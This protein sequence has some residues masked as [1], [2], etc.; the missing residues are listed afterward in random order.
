QVPINAEFGIQDWDCPESF[1]MHRMVKDIHSA[2]NQLE[3]P[4]HHTNEQIDHVRSTI[5]SQWANPPKDV[6]QLIPADVL[7]SIKKQALHSLGIADARQAPF[8]IVLVDGILLFHDGDQNPECHPGLACDTGVFIYAQYDTL[9][10]RREFRTSYATV[11]GV[12]LDPPGYFDHVVWPNFTKYHAGLASE[13]PDLSSETAVG[14]ARVVSDLWNG[15]IAVCS[16]D[17]AAEVTLQ[18]CVET[19]LSEWCNRSHQVL[20]K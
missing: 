20:D 3:R 8:S 17:T 18:Q 16:S 5:A 1:D 7:A 9:K 15:K 11:E 13:H 10:L 12:W 6:D 14:G 19:I 2:R 4:E